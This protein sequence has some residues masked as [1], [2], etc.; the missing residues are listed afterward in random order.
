MSVLK[1]YG[2]DTTSFKPSLTYQIKGAHIEGMIDGIES[3]RQAIELILLTERF[4]WNI[5]STDYGIETK[6]LIGKDRELIKG[7]FERRVSECL[8]EDDRITGISDF[9][10][11]FDRENANVS[12][13]VHTI[14]GD[15]PEERS[16]AIG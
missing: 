2:D 5:L 1:T 9:T 11:S 8:A 4:E 14:F 6:D 16:V 7:D 12:F 3:V 15:V 10:I 13:T